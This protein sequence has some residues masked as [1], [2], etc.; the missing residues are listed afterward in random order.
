MAGLAAWTR[1]PR[2]F[3]W[4]ATIE[5]RTAGG[6]LRQRAAAADHGAQSREEAGVGRWLLPSRAST[7]RATALG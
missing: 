1:C 7:L 5:M 3:A 2:V 6:D 4:S